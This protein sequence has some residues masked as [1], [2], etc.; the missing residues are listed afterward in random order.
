MKRR[1][2]IPLV[3]GAVAAWAIPARAQ[4]PAL[5]VIGFISSA[6]PSPFAHLVAAMRLG[7]GEAGYVEGRTLPS[8]IGGRT[9]SMIADRWSRAK[10]A[11]LGLLTAL[12]RMISKLLRLA[13]R[14]HFL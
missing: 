11:L 7:L 8:S 10:C 14:G 5:P 3:S 2:F 1:D 9:G 13:H 6:S 12:F 4:Q